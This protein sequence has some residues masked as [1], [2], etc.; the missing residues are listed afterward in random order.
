MLFVAPLTDTNRRASRTPSG[1]LYA[2]GSGCDNGKVAK[3]SG[4]RI[5]AAKP[6]S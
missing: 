1:S 5:I 3:K 4:N 2:P 6:K